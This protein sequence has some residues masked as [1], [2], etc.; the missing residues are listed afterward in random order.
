MNK[1]NQFNLAG[2]FLHI[3]GGEYVPMRNI[4]SVEL[5]TD[6]DRSQM[7]ERYPEARNDFRYRLQFWDQSQ[8]LTVELDAAPGIF[9]Q[10]DDAVLVPITNVQGLK[11]LTA[12]DRDRLK[13]RYPNAEREFQTR[14][15]GGAAGQSFLSTWT[16]GRITGMGEEMLTAAPAMQSGR[17]NGAKNP[18]PAG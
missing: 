1:P 15:E 13:A 17:S 12:K 2:N 3:G 16:V 6:A 8:K 11:P 10:V 9:V 5:L 14:I 4:R 7:A 18:A